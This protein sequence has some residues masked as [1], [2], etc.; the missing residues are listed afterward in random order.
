MIKTFTE[1]DCEIL[2]STMNQISLDF[3]LQM[4]PFR[5]FS[6]YNI[7]IINQ[8]KTNKLSSEFPSVRV[9]NSLE[10]GLSKSRNLAI[11]N[12]IGKILI[13]ADDDIIYQKDFI[14]K[15]IVA[16]N[17]LYEATIVNFCAIK[18][19]GAYLKKYPTNSKQQLN[20][21]EILNVSSIEMT[22]K[23]EKLHS[24]GTRFDENFGLGSNSFEMGEETVFLFDLKRKNQQITFENEVIVAHY[25]LT[26]SDKIGILRRYYIYGGLVNRVLEKSGVFGLMLKMFFDIK[27]KKM[28]INLFFK[29]ID[30]FNKGK[31]KI[32]AIN[33]EK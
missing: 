20:A 22:I 26:S 13:I 14:E 6:N 27:Q 19:N 9:I 16:H 12:A 33:Y 15:I 10:I 2:V 30:N 17:K 4:F 29:A 28:K 32:E 7:L 21:M 25:G 31:Q 3:L 8:T 1:N 18:E 23:K 5:H 11:E 24:I